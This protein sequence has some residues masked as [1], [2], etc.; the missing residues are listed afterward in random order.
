MDVE[1]SML[2]RIVALAAICAA[3]SALALNFLYPLSAL[4]RDLCLVVAAASATG[5][6]AAIEGMGLK[7]PAQTKPTINSGR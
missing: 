2:S 1:R 4:K 5:L 6:L 7:S 3:A